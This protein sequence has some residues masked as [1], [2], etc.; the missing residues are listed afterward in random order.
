MTGSRPGT[1][2][3]DGTEA[4]PGARTGVPSPA[5]SPEP[6]PRKQGNLAEVAAV[7]LR[8]GI[9]GFGGPAAHIAMMREEVVVRRRWLDEGRFLDLLSVT[10][11]IPGPN[12]TELAIH[13][14]YER[15]G[16]R[17]L[18]VAG[19]C[20]I[21]PA[22]LTVLALAHLYSTFGATPEANRFLYGV[23]PVILAIVARALW[24][25]GRSMLGDREGAPVRAALAAAVLVLY[26]TGVHELALLFGAA[27]A[28][29]AARRAGRTPGAAVTS[30]SATGARP[31]L[32]AALLAA[33]SGAAMVPYNPGTLF[34]TCLK[35]G[36][37]L[38][39]SGYVLLAF[40]RNDFVL[41]LGWL[42]D[43]QLL[44]AVAV[45]Q[46]TPGPVFT[47]ATFVGYLAGGWTGAAAATA[48]I[49][50]PSF[51]FVAA[52][53][54]LAD[55]LRHWPLTSDLLDGLNVTSLALMAGVTLQLARQALVDGP[56]VALFA[57]ALVLLA[58]ARVNSAWLILAGAALGMAAASRAA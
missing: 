58:R 51:L 25:L 43:G 29:A 44:D 54:P 33:G 1:P 14:G 46:V 36:S 9:L 48:G 42:T 3:P 26:L 50:L 56:A 19:S 37:V 27:L 57:G 18:V 10:H 30:L 11:L 12:S 34:L 4:P 5:G 32:A 15:A 28:Y 2:P 52:I 35:I 22:A 38:Y 24:G 6:A 17:G 8:L 21:L 40:L 39:G 31:R 23:K 53:R 20:F 49:F 7:F 41:R 16:W 45:G 47:T 13:L 55:R